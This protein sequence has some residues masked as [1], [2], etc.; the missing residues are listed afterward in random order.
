MKS[1]SRKLLKPC[2]VC[3][4]DR[5]NRTLH[6]WTRSRCW[7]C[8]WQLRKHFQRDLMPEL[9]AIRQR[10]WAALESKALNGLIAAEVRKA[11]RVELRKVKRLEAQV[12][13]LKA[14]ARNVSNAKT[15]RV[16]RG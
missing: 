15:G 11:T 1:K 8:L 7:L 13:G 2:S 3:Q 4:C 12:A 16:S 5:N 6:E 14:T 9:E 10:E